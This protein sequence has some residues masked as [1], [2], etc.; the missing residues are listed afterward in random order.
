MPF[1]SAA[2]ADPTGLGGGAPDLAKS[3]FPRAVASRIVRVP[4]LRDSLPSQATN[5]LFRVKAV[6]HLVEFDTRTGLWFSDVEIDHDA[7]QPFVL[8]KLARLQPNAV[9]LTPSQVF[10]DLHISEIVDAGFHQ[11]PTDRTASVVL[12]GT[13][14]RVTVTGPAL[15][16]L[17]SEVT[18]T[19]RTGSG[20]EQDPV[21]W[22]GLRR[23]RRRRSARPRS[24]TEARSGDGPVWWSCP[25]RPVPSRCS[26]FC[27]SINCCRAAHSRGA[28]PISMYWTYECC[29]PRRAPTS[30]TV[31]PDAAIGPLSLGPGQISASLAFP[32]NRR[33]AAGRLPANCHAG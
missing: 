11:L 29:Q 13:T 7:D 14:A 20:D 21:V 12:E 8:L 31:F 19:V 23:L 4:G 18:A 27:A 3:T 15:T 1:V 26:C 22:E 17:T 10:E 5:P 16:D 32:D 2:G 30:F 9:P 25:L 28:C 6:G 33:H 24:W